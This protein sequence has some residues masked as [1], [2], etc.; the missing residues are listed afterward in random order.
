M[1]LI[2]S[3]TSP[4]GRKVRI[5]LAEKRIDCE[6]VLTDTSQPDHAALEHNP[7][8]K[9]P[10]L[11]MDDGKP[12]YDSSVIVEYLDHVSPV[13]RLIPNGPRQVV[14]VKRR[15]ALADGVLDAAVAVV[16]E[17]RRPAAQQS[18]EWIAKQTGKIERGVIALAEDLGEKKY[19]LDDSYT[20]ADIAAGSMLAYLNFRLP[21]L[22]WA[23][24]H[25]ALAA[26]LHRL[27]E[28]PSFQ[29]TRPVAA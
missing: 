8:G 5:V 16:A 11:L 28:R 20:L 9:V 18:T 15:E 10:V 22:E 17:R 1:K 2:T 19:L 7:L 24:H 14:S 29:E 27:E 21:E 26:Y 3:L 6:L 13:S 4:Y 12:V 25:P 23:S